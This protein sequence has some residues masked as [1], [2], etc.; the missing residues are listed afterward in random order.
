[1][2]YLLRDLAFKQLYIPVWVIYKLSLGGTK[3]EA[4]K[5][6]AGSIELFVLL[7][8]CEVSSIWMVL[9]WGIYFFEVKELIF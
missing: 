1:M 5:P 3:K 2:K 8:V 4:S 6:K 9:R 7:L